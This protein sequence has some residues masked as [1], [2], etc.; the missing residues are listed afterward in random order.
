MTIQEQKITQRKAGISA[1]R[2]LPDEER[3]AANS[4][5]CAH[6]AALPCFASAK[7]LL[8]YA[9]F[10]GE[11]DLAALAQTAQQLGKTATYPV[12]G[13]GFTLTAA[14]P[15]PDGWE[16]GTYGIRTPVLSRSHIFQPEELDLVLV[17]CTAFDA[18]C[19]RVGMGK[20]YYDRYLPRCTKAVKI[21]IA[22]E[23]QQVGHA[24]VD[25]HD[26]PLDAF[27]TEKGIYR[28]TDKFKL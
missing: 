7:T 25:T 14:V 27:V 23:C 6:L 24:A 2:A 11:A 26:Y 18:E 20:G 3:R 13:E 4:A 19:H 22:F 5:L 9:A 15:E 17:P 12:C 10:G 16:V 28:G 8:V 21:G 1:R